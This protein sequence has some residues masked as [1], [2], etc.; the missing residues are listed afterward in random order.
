MKRNNFQPKF[1]FFNNEK[2]QKSLGDFSID[3]DSYNDSIDEKNINTNIEN[4]LEFPI[5]NNISSINISNNVIDNKKQDKMISFNISS[6]KDSLKDNIK[7]DFKYKAGDFNMMKRST[8]TKENDR[9][10]NISEIYNNNL[11]F[12]SVCESD[13]DDEDMVNLTNNEINSQ[14]N[15][16]NISNIKDLSKD[17]IKGFKATYNY[18]NEKEIEILLEPELSKIYSSEEIG[19]NKNEIIINNEKNKNNNILDNNIIIDKGNS[20]SLNNKKENI[21]LSKD[22]N[23]IIN[24]NE[25]SIN[26]EQKK[27]NQDLRDSRK[28][29]QSHN[30]NNSKKSLTILS[31]TKHSKIFQKFLCVGIDTSGLYSLDNDMEVLLLNPKITYNYPYNKSERELE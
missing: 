30:N 7:N 10:S 11:R 19:D 2:P 6:N 18:N 13:F 16:S 3:C 27:A 31:L 26:K 12:L 22:K 8:W 20:N 9:Y 23:N 28:F 5:E 14:S 1:K 4:S 21:A 17:Y 24:N 29:F 15:I 25:N